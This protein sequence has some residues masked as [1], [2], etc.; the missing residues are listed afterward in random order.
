MFDNYAKNKPK[1]VKMCTSGFISTPQNNP[2]F[3]RFPAFNL[4][5]NGN[6]QSVG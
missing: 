5:S 2:G 6:K 3:D 4:N 1:D